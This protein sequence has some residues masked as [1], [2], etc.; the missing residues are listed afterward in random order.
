MINKLGPI[1]SDG[2]KRRV[3]ANVARKAA[4]ERVAKDIRNKEKMGH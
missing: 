3:D 1:H 2:R 4:Q